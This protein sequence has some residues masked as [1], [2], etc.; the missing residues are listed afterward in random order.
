MGPAEMFEKIRALL[1]KGGYEMMDEGEDSIV[2][3]ATG[4]HAGEVWVNLKT[5]DSVVLGELP[6][7]ALQDILYT[8]GEEDEDE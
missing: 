5:K 7:N 6:D 3:E 2:E 1:E 8:Y 4:T